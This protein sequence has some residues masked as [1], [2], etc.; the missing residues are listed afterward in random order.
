MSEIS[1]KTDKDLLKMLKDKREAV[2]ASRFSGA[3][4]KNKNV[5]EVNGLKKEIARIMTVLSSRK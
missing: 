3:G 5:K 4:S 1:T 2:R